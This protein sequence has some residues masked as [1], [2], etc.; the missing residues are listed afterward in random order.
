MAVSLQEGLA[1]G[2]SGLAL[3]ICKPLFNLDTTTA[4]LGGYLVA[5][6][7][8]V[9]W[10]RSARCLIWQFDRWDRLCDA[11]I[12][13]PHEI[14]EMKTQAKDRYRKLE[15]VPSKEKDQS[16]LIG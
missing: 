14:E 2:G 11:G 4:F 16:N 3:L 10:F 1:L 12:F 13:L 5:L 7:P 15:G 9:L 8:V 6:V